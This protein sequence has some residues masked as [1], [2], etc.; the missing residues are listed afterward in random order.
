MWREGAGSLP[1]PL[2]LCLPSLSSFSQP[3]WHVRLVQEVSNS[4][5][6]RKGGR[7]KR[8]ME[9]GRREKR[10]EGEER[11]GGGEYKMRTKGVS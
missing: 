11:N 5:G 3:S 6:V 9:G 4:R 1:L 8:E 2:H 10:R 7:E